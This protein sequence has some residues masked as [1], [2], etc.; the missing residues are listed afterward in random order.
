MNI[1][2]N[3]KKIAQG[4]HCKK[5]FIL[6]FTMLI[7]TLVLFVS[8]SALTLLTKQ[9]YFSKMYKLSQAAYYASDDAISC[10]I[11]VDDSYVGADG[12]G[13]FPNDV[14]SYTANGNSDM[15]Y[16]DGV[17]QYANTTHGTAL[18][19]LDITCA[20][21][22][23]FD[24]TPSGGNFH[25]EETFSHTFQNGQVEQGR[26]V[27]YNMRMDLGL[28]PTDVTNTRHLFRC[29]KVTVKKTASFRQIIA[30]GY[31]QCDNPNGSVERAVV[32]T[33]EVQ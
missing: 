25:S 29:A 18:T 23:I 1:F 27:S 11:A 13:I 9:L 28:D 5:G 22:T 21:S 6:P 7:S 8:G 15:T 17:L 20:Q 26:V 32:N 4:R 33:T 16:I 14:A 31:A 19:L 2:C 12:L 24:T 3:Y 10:A 30:Q